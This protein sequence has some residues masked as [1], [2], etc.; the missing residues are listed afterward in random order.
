MKYRTREWVQI[1]IVLE[2]LSAHALSLFTR[3]TASNRGKLNTDLV[4]VEQADKISNDASFPAKLLE[5]QIFSFWNLLFYHSCNE[6][7]FSFNDFS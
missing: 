1:P 5:L 3:M 2:R 6:L 4:I 7:V